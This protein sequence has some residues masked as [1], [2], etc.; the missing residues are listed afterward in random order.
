MKRKKKVARYESMRKEKARE[1]SRLRSHGA[2][3]VVVAL[4]VSPRETEKQNSRT[5]FINAQFVMKLILLN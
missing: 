1:E 3:F 2:V 5:Q 4:L